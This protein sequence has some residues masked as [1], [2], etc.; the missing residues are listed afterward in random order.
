MPRYSTLPAAEFLMFA[1]LAAIVAPVSGASAQALNSTQ[2]SPVISCSDAPNN[3]QH[4][5]QIVAACDA[6][7]L[8]RE[9]PV[10]NRLEAM[11]KRLQVSRDSNVWFFQKQDFQFIEAYAELDPGNTPVKLMIA[12]KRINER[13]I[14]EAITITNEVLEKD[15]SNGTA[16]LIRGSAKLLHDESYTDITDLSEAV[17]LLPDRSEPLMLLGM[18]ME[19]RF[20]RF[21]KAGALYA[22]ALALNKRGTRIFDI[23]VYGGAQLPAEALGRVL[24]RMQDSEAAIKILTDVLADMPSNF[25]RDKVLTHRVEAYR[26]AGDIPNAISDVNEMM[27]YV[28][29]QEKPDL[30]MRRAFLKRELKQYD[31]AMADI[32]LATA[33]GN[34]K[35]I[36]QLQVKLRNAGQTSV[37]INGEFDAATKAGLI[38]C[39]S[40]KECG[41]ILGTPI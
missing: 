20:G 26:R 36:L 14:S 40:D 8:N 7:A 34:L 31:Q 29:E 9:Q 39:M 18:V 5:I 30:L 35:M 27:K 4:A 38:D 11:K 1:A 12:Q 25:M 33:N 19:T 22:R 32:A 3:R 13:K 6:V 17:R 21:A 15:P 24:L 37:E 28:Q 10:P 23:A 2:V 16:R 41:V